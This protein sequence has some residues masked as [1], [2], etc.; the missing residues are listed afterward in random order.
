MGA[1]FCEGHVRGKEFLALGAV[2]FEVGYIAVI[3]SVCEQI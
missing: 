1:M 2:S 3:L